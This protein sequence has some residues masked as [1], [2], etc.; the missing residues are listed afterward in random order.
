MPRIS[1]KCK[2]YK[3]QQSSKSTNIPNIPALL[4]GW[5]VGQVAAMRRAAARHQA[6][7]RAAQ[8]PDC[9]LTALEPGDW[10]ATQWH[11]PLWK[12]A[13][14]I[15]IVFLELQIFIKNP[16]IPKN[17]L[18]LLAGWPGGQVG[19]LRRAA[20]KHQ[21]A[22]RAAQWPYAGSRHWGQVAG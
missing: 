11:S 19:A 13:I 12:S 17:I 8:W 22:G 1:K 20:T 21:A 7:G 5:P 6:A 4:S 2:T 14:A 15:L 3:K 16:E 9:R 18:K 10:A